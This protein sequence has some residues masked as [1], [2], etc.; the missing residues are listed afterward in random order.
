MEASTQPQDRFLIGPVEVTKEIPLFYGAT[1]DA[2]VARCPCGW[3]DQEYVGHLKE[4]EQKIQQHERESSTS[5][6]H[7]GFI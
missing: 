1:P 3:K 7:E 2:W 6:D 4:L 5:K